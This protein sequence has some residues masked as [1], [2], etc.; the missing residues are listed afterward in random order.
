MSDFI[1]N[2]LGQKIGVGDIVGRGAR[3]GNTSSFKIGRVLSFNIDK[4]IAK[5]NWLYEPTDWWKIE[6]GE[7]AWTEINSQGS[8][9][10]DTLFLL[11]PATFGFPVQ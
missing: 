2:W 4:Q 5:I 3:D 9:N 11:D 6:K 7:P 10:V 1:T 8:P